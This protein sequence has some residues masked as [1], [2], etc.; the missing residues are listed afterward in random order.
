MQMEYL[1]IE[2]D[3]AEKINR[4]L[5]NSFQK[6]FIKDSNMWKLDLK[7][8]KWIIKAS[9][10]PLPSERAIIQGTPDFRKPS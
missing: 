9:E 10:K 5:W 8:K 6:H 4:F 3:A 1:G 7:T 2:F